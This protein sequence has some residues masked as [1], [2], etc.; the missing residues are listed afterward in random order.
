MSESVEFDYAIDE[1]VD[2]VE[3]GMTGVVKALSTSVNGHEYRVV[4]WNNG[5]LKLE[6]M[7]PWEIAKASKSK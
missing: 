4:F 7:R 5:E 1:R 6:W 3:I 2:I